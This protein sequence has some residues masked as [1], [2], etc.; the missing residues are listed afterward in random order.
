MNDK[1]L[2]NEDKL[3][4]LAEINFR[5][6]ERE[7][8]EQY[9]EALQMDDR[10]T[11]EEFESFGDYPRQMAT[12]KAHFARAHATFGFTGPAMNEHGWAE[13]ESFLD[14]E[15]FSFGKGIKARLMGSNNVTI[16]RGPNGKW[17]YALDLSVSLSGRYGGL[18]VFDEP[19]DS[20]RACLRCALEE[21]IAW[22]TKENDK[23]TTPVI[24]EA[25]GILD[26]ITGRKPVQLT[27]F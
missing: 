19:Y 15:T 7:I 10:A 12:N 21:L 13:Q 25:K 26:E 11:I 1:D 8:V 27:L 23:K 2:S 9:R 20:R 5:R 16:G 24:R 18:S 22:H 3:T 6:C 14:C 4:A 17:T